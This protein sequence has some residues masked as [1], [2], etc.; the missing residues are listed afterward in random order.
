MVHVGSRMLSFSIIHTVRYVHLS[1]WF[2][3]TS[4]NLICRCQ[5]IVTVK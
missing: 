3:M 2:R 4:I 5:V 1:R